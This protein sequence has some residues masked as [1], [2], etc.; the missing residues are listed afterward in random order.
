VLITALISLQ[1]N[2]YI[3]RITVKSWFINWVLSIVGRYRTVIYVQFIS[4]KNLIFYYYFF[5][6]LQP[7]HIEKIFVKNWKRV[8]Q[9]HIRTYI[10]LIKDQNLL[11]DSWQWDNTQCQKGKNC[12]L[13]I[14][15]I[16]LICPNFFYE[17]PSILTYKVS[18][19]PTHVDWV[20]KS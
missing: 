15:T 14:V 7:N 3:F 5:F 11:A 4:M 2:K 18:Y 10:C 19:Y 6:L 13:D 9:S 8:T 17:M 12:H 1:T 16:F 20:L